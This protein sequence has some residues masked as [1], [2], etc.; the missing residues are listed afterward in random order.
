MKWSWS[1]LCWSLK[2]W[3]DVCGRE[4]RARGRL[5]RVLLEMECSWEREAWSIVCVMPRAWETL[6]EASSTSDRDR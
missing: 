3:T 1:G 4:G 6:L 5:G 2:C